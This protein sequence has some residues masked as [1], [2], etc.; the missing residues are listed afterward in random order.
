MCVQTTNEHAT[1]ILVFSHSMI[2]GGV[3]SRD[4]IMGLRWWSN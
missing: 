1:H 4:I 3:V 2:G